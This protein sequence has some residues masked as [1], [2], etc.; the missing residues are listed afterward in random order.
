MPNDS[1]D[2]NDNVKRE[3]RMMMAFSAGIV[4][5]ILGMMGANML[6]H[7]PSQAE[8]QTEFS[9]QSRPAAPN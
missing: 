9:S 4:A 1:N 3:T 2:N 6:F 5:L 7:H 8:L